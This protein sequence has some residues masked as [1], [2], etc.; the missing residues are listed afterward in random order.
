MSGER[1]VELGFWFIS[2]QKK[3]RPESKAFDKKDDE[4]EKGEKKEKKE[5][6]KFEKG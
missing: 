2:K 1:D 4:E 6:R 5:K 3:S